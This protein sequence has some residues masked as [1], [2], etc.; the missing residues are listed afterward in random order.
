MKL[1]KEDNIKEY[2]DTRLHNSS[3]SDIFFEMKK[4]VDT[5]LENKTS[6]NFISINHNFTPIFMYYAIEAKIS[7]LEFEKILQISPNYEDGLNRFFDRADFDYNESKDGNIYD[8]M[9]M[10]K[11]FLMRKKYHI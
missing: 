3:W 2:I 1:I 8:K 11:F 10:E 4:E 9:K 5:L 7:L 6:K